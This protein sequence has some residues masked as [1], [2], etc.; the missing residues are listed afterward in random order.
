MLSDVEGQRSCRL[1]RINDSKTSKHKLE[2]HAVQMVMATLHTDVDGGVGGTLSYTC[3]AI[4]MQERLM[5]A[6]AKFQNAH[7]T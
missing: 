1:R 2:R 5:V 7:S 4:I 3:A 6:H